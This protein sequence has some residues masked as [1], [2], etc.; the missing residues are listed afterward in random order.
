VCTIQV[1]VQGGK[2]GKNGASR[3]VMSMLQT[4]KN[5]SSRAVHIEPIRLEETFPK[6]TALD[7]SVRS[8]LE[9]PKNPVHPWFSLETFNEIRRREYCTQGSDQIDNF[10]VNPWPGVLNAYEERGATL[11]S[12]SFGAVLFYLQRN[13]I[14]RELLS[15]GIVKAYIPPA[16]Y[17][18]LEDH[19]IA[20]FATKMNRT[21]QSRNVQTIDGLSQLSQKMQVD[22]FQGSLGKGEEQI[23][24]LSLD[25]TA[26]K[27][28][29]ILVNS[30]DN[31]PTGS[32]WRHVNHTKC[33]HGSRLLRA[34]MLRPMFRKYL[35]DRRTD[36]VAE[37]V[38]GAASLAIQEARSALSKCGDI[39]R[40]LYRV[41]SM[42]CTANPTTC[43]HPSD[44]AV[45]HENVTYTTNKVTDFAKLLNGLQKAATIPVMF[46]H[47]EIRND[48]LRKL[49][50]VRTQDCKD[51][52]FPDMDEL[53]EWFFEY[54]DIEEAAKGEFEMKKGVAREYDD[55]RDTIKRIETVS[56]QNSVR[57]EPITLFL[58][59]S[60][61]A[62]TLQE[63]HQFKENM[64]SFCR[65][66]PQNVARDGWK[67]VNTKP[68]SKDKYMIELPALVKVPR[69]FTLK[70]K[71][72]NGSNAVITYQ[73]K[74][75][76]QLVVEL[77]LALE[78]KN[79]LRDEGWQIMLARF[80]SNR[81]I[82]DAAAQATAFL[83]ALGSLA[84]TSSQ[85]GYT[86]ATI[87]ECYANGSP[88]LNVIQGRHPIFEKNCRA[89]EFVPND[90]SLG[91]NAQGVVSQPVLLLSGANM[92]GKSTFLR[93][94][95]LIAI[96]A[97]IGCFVPAEK[98]SLTPID[99]IYTRLGAFDRILQ[100]QSTFFVEVLVVDIACSKNA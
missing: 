29:E 36:A 93:Q 84:K 100:G 49:V 27:N 91:R 34:W 57:K 75:V 56:S 51:G 77:E 97:Q 47:L 90:L 95:C 88:S 72:G 96:L 92:G 40:L 70:S 71:R 20:I 48:L 61:L 83:D 26:L 38:S 18:G 98:C 10:C 99:R 24:H 35:I 23:D 32:L 15:M 58:T 89:K 80:H 55:A 8:S 4:Y 65:L 43:V 76:Q 81:N 46:Q 16:S 67:Y 9:R 73:A 2:N 59:C 5:T 52:S 69:D 82:W 31:K 85:S 6:S 14:D 22:H 37:L 33:P 64:C 30:V 53:L 12:S 78:V 60:V 7:Q 41:H 86:R 68:T 3:I 74:G 11:V 1:L 17:A 54:L 28:L 44:R 62:P 94:T 50:T 19:D 63:I 87:L 42:S 39:E 45:L 66:T 79:K 21:I 25:G 13:L